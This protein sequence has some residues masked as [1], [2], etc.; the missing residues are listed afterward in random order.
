MKKEIITEYG[1]YKCNHSIRNVPKFILQCFMKFLG[2]EIR[3]GTSKETLC[4]FITKY[5]EYEK[6]SKDKIPLHQVLKKESK[7]SKENRLCGSKF[8]EKDWN[9]MKERFSKI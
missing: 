2:V 3:K 9:K 6:N 1:N 4:N 7:E 5:Y 8:T